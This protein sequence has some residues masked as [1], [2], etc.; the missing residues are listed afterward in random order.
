MRTWKNTV[1]TQSHR[2][3]TQNSEAPAIW[4]WACSAD[5]T[6]EPHSTKTAAFAPQTIVHFRKYTHAEGSGHPAA[7]WSQSSIDAGCKHAQQPFCSLRWSPTPETSKTRKI[8]CRVVR[9]GCLYGASRG[10]RNARAPVGKRTGVARLPAAPS[11]TRG[12]FSARTLG[13]T[14]C[15]PDTRAAPVLLHAPWVGSWQHAVLSA[16]GRPPL[17]WLASRCCG[18]DG[19]IVSAKNGARTEFL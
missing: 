6:S 16:Q 8:L 2:K 17:L 9:D 14:P 5:K 7:T 13:T 19:F 3:M 10:S 12:E 4:S 18:A 15:R 11:K 1:S